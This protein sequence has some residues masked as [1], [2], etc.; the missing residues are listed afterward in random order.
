[1]EKFGPAQCVA[2]AVVKA[3]AVNVCSANGSS[4]NGQTLGMSGPDSP[5]RILVR[6]QIRLNQNRA[7]RLELPA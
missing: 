2:V 1:M 6:A 3:F 5:R 4:C 7:S